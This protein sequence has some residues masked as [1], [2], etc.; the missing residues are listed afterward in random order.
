[1]TVLEWFMKRGDEIMG[2]IRYN[3]KMLV[4]L[5]YLKRCFSAMPE[6]EEK[7]EFS[8]VMKGWLLYGFR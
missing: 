3:C 4:A 7:E 5:W 1:M 8:Y 6:G 2:K